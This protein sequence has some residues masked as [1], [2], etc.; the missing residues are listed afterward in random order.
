METILLDTGVMEQPFNNYFL[1]CSCLLLFGFVDDIIKGQQYE[2]DF[3]SFCFCLS[4]SSYLLSPY[5]VI[6]YLHIFVT[7]FSYFE[8]LRHLSYSSLQTDHSRLIIY[9]I[10]TALSVSS[11]ADFPFIDYFSHNY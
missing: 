11:T 3:I 2:S 6:S 4:L 8:L 10:L 9:D 1:F 5:L 7:T